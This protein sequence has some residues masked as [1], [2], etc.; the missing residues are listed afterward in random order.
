MKELMQKAKARREE[1]RSQWG[2]SPKSVNNLR[3]MKTMYTG[4]Q[5]VTF[6]AEKAKP[7]KP[8]LLRLAV[9][10]AAAGTRFDRILFQLELLA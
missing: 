5:S 6:S 2:V 4:V 9:T 8:S 10:A 3:T 7:A 1:F